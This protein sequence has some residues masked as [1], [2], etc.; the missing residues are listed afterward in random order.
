MAITH[1]KITGYLYPISVNGFY[2]GAPIVL[3]QLYPIADQNLLSFERAIV[4][5]DYSIINY[6]EWQLIDSVNNVESNVSKGVLQFLKRVNAFDETPTGGN[7]NTVLLNN[8]TF[9]LIDTTAI[10]DNVEFIEIDTIVGINNWKLNGNIIYPGTRIPT[11]VLNQVFFEPNET[12]GGRPYSSLNFNVGNKTEISNSKYSHQILV[13]TLAE[14]FNINESEIQYTDSYGAVPDTY[15]TIQQSFIIEIQNAYAN[16]EV[17][18]EVNI[19]SPF[20]NLNT[21]NKVLIQGSF[22]TLEKFANETFN[23]T[24]VTDSKGKAQFDLI[25]LIVEDAVELKTGG[26]TLTVLNVNGNTNLVALTNNVLTLN[27]NYP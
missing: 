21:Y 1:F 10:D 20:L 19:N 23:I 18:I 8:E 24:T 11:A 6:F 5:S 14:I 17:E 2:D 7:D 4:F 12:G 13:D 15:N 16:A 26:V 22:G 25:N 27:T 3:N 9:N